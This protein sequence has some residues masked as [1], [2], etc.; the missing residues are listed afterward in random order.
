MTRIQRASGR[1]RRGCLA[2]LADG[3]ELQSRSAV[4][5]R[6]SRLFGNQLGAPPANVI[7][8]RWLDWNMASGTGVRGHLLRDAGPTTRMGVDLAGEWSRLGPASPQTARLA[9]LGS[10]P[11]S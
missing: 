5:K 7:T 8:R 10:R 1:V 9:S 4:S 2:I 11:S 6:V 3:R